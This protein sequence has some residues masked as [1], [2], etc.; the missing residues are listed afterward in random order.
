MMECIITANCSAS[1][2]NIVI[3]RYPV[4][5][6]KNGKLYKVKGKYAAFDDLVMYPE[7]S[8]EEDDEF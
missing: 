6:R 2:Y 7:N 4:N 8:D 5:C 3:Y 1:T